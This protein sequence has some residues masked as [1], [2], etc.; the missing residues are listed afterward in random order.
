MATDEKT[1]RS[2]PAMPQRASAEERA[3]AVQ[4]EQVA[5]LHL[6]P[7]VYFST[8]SHLYELVYQRRP[9]GNLENPFVEVEIYTLDFLS[10]LREL[11]FVGDNWFQVI[12]ALSDE[13]ERAALLHLSPHYGSN[14]GHFSRKTPDARPLDMNCVV[15]LRPSHTTL[16]I[17]QLIEQD[18]DLWYQT[19]LYKHEHEQEAPPPEPSASIECDQMGSPLFDVFARGRLLGSL[20]SHVRRP[21]DDALSLGI[22]IVRR[23]GGILLR[24]DEQ[25]DTLQWIKLGDTASTGNGESREG[26]RRLGEGEKEA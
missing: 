9:V 15:L 2:L 23:E 4:G 5:D 20:V 16:Q 1:E 14:L 26:K 8:G 17:A 18:G 12:E 3:S 21:F 10:T 11:P 6:L 19:A 7:R 22:E 13:E 24:Y 25:E